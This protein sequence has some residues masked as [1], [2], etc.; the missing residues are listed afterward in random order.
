MKIKLHIAAVFIAAALSASAATWTA[1]APGEYKWDASE[2]W[3]DGVLPSA[4]ADALLNESLYRPTG[5]QT[6]TGDGAA[7]A[8][9]LHNNSP[10]TARTFT[11]NLS[12][13]KLVLR[14][15]TM[16]VAGT[17]D[18][19]DTGGAYSIVGAGTE[20]NETGG[21]LNIMDGG[22]VRAD[23][24]HAICVGRRGAVDNN[25][26]S[27]RIVL[28]DGGRFVLNPSGT[29][30]SMAGLQLGRHDGN[31]TG[32]YSA[33][34]VQEGGESVLGRIMTGFEKK[35]HAG[36]AVLG[37]AMTLPYINDDTRFRIGHKGYGAFQLLGGDV[38]VGTNR[39]SAVA[40]ADDKRFGQRMFGF[41]VGSGQNADDGLKGAY[42]Y[43]CAGSF[44]NTLDFAIQGQSY[45]K[46]G[47]NPAH[48]TID[49]SAC[50]TSR[51]VRV[52]ANDGDGRATLN[53]NGGVLVTDAIYANPNRAGRSE[54]NADGGKIV[55][56]ASAVQ[57][58][59]LFLDAMNIY[60]GGLEIDVAGRNTYLGNAGTN[61]VLRTPGGYGVDIKALRNIGSNNTP[62][63]IDI[64]GGSGTNAAA[65]S[66]IDYGT[67]DMTNATIVCRGEGYKPGDTPV[68]TV[69]RP[70]GTTT[71][72][73]RIE[74]SV[75]ENKPG[76]LVKTG[77]YD[78]S[79]FAQPEFAGTYECRQGW[80][81]QTTAAGTGSPKVAAIVVGGDNA[82]FQTGSGNDTAVAA[83]WNPVNPEASLALGTEH[84]PGILNVPGAAAGEAAPFEQSFASLAVR[85]TGNRID[86]APGS[87]T[88]VGAKVTFGSVSFEDGA[89]LTIPKWDS[90]FKV[91]VTGLRAGAFVR[92]VRFDGVNPDVFAMVA[93]DGQLV[94]AKIGLTITVW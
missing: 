4:A 69:T 60:E 68:A 73:D 35:T 41:E 27:G 87:S 57:T 75:S 42:L 7:K 48:A 84:G 91:Y 67:G 52:G 39:S 62:P 80:L 31:R 38:T 70:Y 88:A 45:S 32:I 2:N 92:N 74:L 33:A 34:Y 12:V 59:F 64:S 44:W 78:L 58:Q 82:H 30:G 77:G 50:V 65:V 15:G 61:V 24:V 1:K 71:L 55:F 81:R 89:V 93:E 86:W 16:N 26:A 79:L 14:I 3:K 83:N 37:G 56:L 47:V 46:T 28:K 5:A 9:D 53:L 29:T 22:T 76:A 90:N 8:L 40:L 63:W 72:T 17:L 49:G 19:T 94:K 66:L 18:L 21:F 25:N 85:G 36:V 6:I 13:E 43:A 23:G 10:S 11:G 54:L 20:S 51:T